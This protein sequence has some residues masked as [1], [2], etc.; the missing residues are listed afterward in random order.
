M[1]GGGSTQ[2]PQLT[3][4]LHIITKILQLTLIIRWDMSILETR[5]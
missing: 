4:G 5:T 3:L 2:L 1:W